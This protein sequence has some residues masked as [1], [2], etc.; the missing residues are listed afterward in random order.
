MSLV[1]HGL[2][3]NSYSISIFQLSP[4]HPREII[5][6]AALYYYLIARLNPLVI[7]YV[8]VF[9]FHASPEPSNEDVVRRPASPIHADVDL[10]LFEKPGAVQIFCALLMSFSARSDSSP[11]ITLSFLISFKSS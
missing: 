3:K 8:G 10:A 5:Q 1:A 9:V 4:E 2:E 11:S 7:T 6:R